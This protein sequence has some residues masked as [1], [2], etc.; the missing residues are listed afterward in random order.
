MKRTFLLKTVILLCALVA[1]SSSVW[2]DDYV[3]YSGTITEG[4]Y[5]I[6]YNGYAL[7]NTVSSS[8]R[9]DNQSVT[10]SENKISNP[11]A[12]IVWHIA[13]DGDYW[14]IYNAAVNKYAGGNGSKNQGALLASVTNYAKWTVTG[15]T[16]Y[17]FENKGRAEG[18]SNTGNKWLRNN[19]TNGWACYTDGTGGA[20]SL[21]KKAVAHTVTFSINGVTSE[22][23]VVEG[24]AITF[25]ANPAAI[26]GKEFVGW[27]TATISGTTDEAPDVLVTSATMGNADVTYYAVFANKSSGETV[28]TKTITSDISGFPSGSYPSNKE[29]TFDGIK[30]N[31]NKAMKST[32]KMQFQ[33]STGSI[34]NI[35]ALNKIKSV[36]ITYDTSDNYKNFTLNLGDAAN[37]TSGTSISPTIS[38][39]VYTFDCSSYNKDYFL[40]KNGSNAGYLT[41]IEIN[42]T[43]TADIYSDYCTTVSTTAT[44]TL[45]SA[46]TDGSLYYGTYSKGTAF[47][48]PSDLIV[49]EIS[50]FDGQLYIE[51]YDTDDVVPAN[52]GVLVVSDVAG[53]HT[54]TLTT[55]AGTSLLGD[56]NMLKPSG[57]NGVT[58]SDMADTDYYYYRLTMYNEKPGF[59][60]KSDNGAGFAL[61]AN[62]AYLKVPTSEAGTVASLASGFTLGDHETTG[63]NDVRSKTEDT[64]NEVYNLA[65]QRVTQPTKGLYIVNGHKVVIK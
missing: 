44:I 39:Q 48:V 63:V 54:V 50:V 11:D 58:A 32:T 46:C 51:D 30:Y 1:G 16:T 4:D 34:N 17:E 62:K 52:T 28:S 45:A 18:S 40:L 60:W 55:E 56:D 24:D 57:D 2:A 15:T 25:P 35:D 6:Y 22:D 21:Y 65:G 33:A 38:D 8:N 3:L 47:V 36:V 14:T 12:A 20:L 31:V 61:A 7:K 9:F 42:Y 23:N 19:G 64:R 53:D 26:G 29:C 49:S 41:T 5:V 43:V 27:T 59:W 10:P 37:P 13:K